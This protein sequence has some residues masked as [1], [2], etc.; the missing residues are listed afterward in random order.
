MRKLPSLGGLRSFEAA[1]RHM[2]FKRAAA[3]LNV[4]PTAIS[5]E[6]L[7]ILLAHNLVRLEM[8]RLGITKSAI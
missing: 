4:T 3:E 6:L 1:A 2:S 8:E 5:Q 7:G